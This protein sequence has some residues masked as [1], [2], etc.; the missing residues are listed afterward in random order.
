MLKTRLQSF[1]W[2]PIKLVSVY[3]VIHNHAVL[4]EVVPNMLRDSEIL[5]IESQSLL[6]NK[7]AT[8]V[9]K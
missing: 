9:I 4:P 1:D 5:K 8:L 2:I 7:K 6:K 3:L